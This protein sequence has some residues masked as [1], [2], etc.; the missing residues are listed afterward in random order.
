MWTW[1]MMHHVWLIHSF[2]M[3]Y[4]W[5]VVRESFVVTCDAVCS[6]HS[7]IHHDLCLTRQNDSFMPFESSCWTWHMMHYVW[8]I[9]SFTPHFSTSEHATFEMLGVD[10]WRIYMARSHM[11]YIR[12]WVIR[13]SVICDAYVTYV[14]RGSFVVICDSWVIRMSVICDSYVTYVVRESDQHLTSQMSRAQ[15]C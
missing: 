2:I 6:T 5:H 14:V 12:T 11:W 7:F 10:M 9:H 15:M 4:V 1:H 3:I 8:L 13:M